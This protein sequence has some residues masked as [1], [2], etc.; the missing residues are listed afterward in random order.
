MATRPTNVRYV[1]LFGLCLAAGL[2]YI[3]RNCISI[4]KTTVG[5]ELGV[6]DDQMAAMFA[7]FFW[8]YALF[9]IPT[10]RLVDRW[11][12]RRSLFVFGLLGAATVAMGT[13]TLWLA[14]TAGFVLL[15]ASRILMGIAQAGLFPGSTRAIAVWMPQSQRAFAAGMLQAWMSLGA[16]V[17]AGLTAALMA[18]LR[19]QWILAVYALP[20][21]AWSVWFFAWF[22]DRPDQH[23]RTNAAE[24]ELLR[25]AGPQ[26]RSG[27][28]WTAVMADRNVL[29]VFAQQFF[30]AGSNAFWFTWA[31]TYLKHTCEVS[32][33]EAGA[34]TTVP[35]V[36]VIV[37]SILGGI[38]ADRVFVRTHSRRA[39]RSGVAI[40]ATLL[41][42]GFFGLA[43]LVPVGNPVQTVIMLS[44][45]TVIVSCGNSCGYSAAM[46]LG[47]RNVATVF[48]AMNMFGNF[49]AAVLSH[50]VPPWASAFGWPAAVLL[51]GG[52]YFCG[53]ICWL[54]LN[55]DHK[56]DPEA[57]DYDDLPA[58]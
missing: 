18:L 47:G 46:D 16:A 34:L 3:H 49:G 38:V 55:P 24:R 31:P 10:G 35:I 50:L 6:T 58:R 9:Q 54:P 42:A 17:V 29:L 51:V 2:A 43:F 4:V 26:Q 32:E 37:G 39:S 41:G 44:V 57:A 27:G 7:A 23:P 22:R 40:V 48:G 11:G 13:G 15:V 45:A 56:P 12:P 36:G 33:Q 20:G 5:D 8:S 1:V 19:W 30:R 53:A 21:V 28:G 52:S 14:A 25:S